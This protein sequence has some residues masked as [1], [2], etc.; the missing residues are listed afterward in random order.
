MCGPSLTHLLRVIEAFFGLSDCE[1]G[2]LSLS[3]YLFLSLVCQHRVIL[4]IY[5]V[6]HVIRCVHLCVSFMSFGSVDGFGGS[7]VLR[8]ALSFYFEV[9]YFIFTIRRG[10]FKIAALQRIRSIDN[11]PDLTKR[12]NKRSSEKISA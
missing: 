3:I 5:S 2:C 10:N 8:Y 9:L 7:R 1:C 4:T 6:D 11:A 12:Q